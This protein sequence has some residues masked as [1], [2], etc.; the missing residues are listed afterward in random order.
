MR[1]VPAIVLASCA[2][3]A[4]CGETPG[5]VT[6]PQSTPVPVPASPEAHADPDATFIADVDV[7]ALREANGLRTDADISEEAEYRSLAQAG[8]AYLALN[9]S[10]VE[11]AVD[12]RRVMRA[13]FDGET[14]L[15]ATDQPYEAVSRKMVAAGATVE[16]EVTVHDPLSVGSGGPGLLVVGF[17][18]EA[19]RAAQ[20]R[21]GGLAPGLRRVLERAGEQPVRAASLSPK[22]ACVEAV[23]I[24][25]GGGDQGTV[26]VE[27]DDK[28]SSTR[29]RLGRPVGIGQ[30][31]FQDAKVSGA[32]LTVPFTSNDANPA[33]LIDERL[34]RCP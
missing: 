23:A 6:A 4:A 24:G 31:A 7:S 10:S 28:A 18:A 12:H 11:A 22:G 5:A 21:D 33:L 15:I 34:Y 32:R 8:L 9:A 13:I 1:S 19:I 17:D 26:D 16:R 25:A 2:L 29:L 14:I 20:A 27:V 3:T 30:F